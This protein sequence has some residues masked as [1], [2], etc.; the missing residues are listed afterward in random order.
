MHAFH[1]QEQCGSEQNGPHGNLELLG[2]N[3]AGAICV[4]QVECLP[5][6]AKDHYRLALKASAASVHPQSDNR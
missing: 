4:E 1:L 2:V 5:G 6:E 3:G